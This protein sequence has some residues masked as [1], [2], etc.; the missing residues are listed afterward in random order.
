MSY[1]ADTRYSYKNGKG[2]SVGT[3]VHTLFTVQGKSESA[4]IAEIKKRHGEQAQVTIVSIEW[5]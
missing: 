2:N 1:K 3:N 4:V 5:K